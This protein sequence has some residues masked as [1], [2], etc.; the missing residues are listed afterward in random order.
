MKQLLRI[1]RALFVAEF[2][3][4]AQYRVQG[5]LW[6]LF[7]ILRPVIFLAAWV[8]VAEARGGSVAG[9]DA[10]DFAAYFVALTLVTQLT[11][12]GVSWEFE[13][14]VRQGKLSPKLLRPLHP[15]HYTVASNVVW[16]LISIAVLLP[17]LLA[18]AW[19]SGARFGADI[20][21]VVLFLPSVVLAAALRFLFSWCVAAT[22]FWTTRVWAVQHLFD[23]ISFIVG[24]Q[25]APIGL[26]PGPLQAIAYVLPFGYMLGVPTDIVRGAYPIDQALLFV[27]GQVLWVVAT[28][29]ALQVIWR[30]GVRQYSAVGA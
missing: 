11:M 10:S 5:I 7:S 3:S 6:M 18:L 1:Y 22:A 15:I 23:R 16:K 17:I 2:Q 12:S 25:I 8:A 24:G 28:V 19:S 21:H 30:L 14:E 4:A 20:W 27:G 26:L 9:Y 29:A 13:Q